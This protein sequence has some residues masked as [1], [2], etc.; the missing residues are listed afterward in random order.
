MPYFSSFVSGLFSEAVPADSRRSYLR[1]RVF[2]HY[3]TALY[4]YQYFVQKT[5]HTRTT[6]CNR[7]TDLISFTGFE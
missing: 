1:R 3:L 4:R 7:N 2:G 5:K 6:K